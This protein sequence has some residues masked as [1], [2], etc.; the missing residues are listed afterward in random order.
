MKAWLLFRAPWNTLFRWL[1]WPHE[2]LGL[3]RMRAIFGQDVDAR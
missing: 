1:A 2:R 3:A